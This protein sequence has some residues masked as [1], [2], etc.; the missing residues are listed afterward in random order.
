MGA[1]RNLNNWLKFYRN[2]HNLFQVEFFW[3]YQG[4]F[5]SPLDWQCRLIIVSNIVLIEI[6]IN[7][8]TKKERPFKSLSIWILVPPSAL[9]SELASTFQTFCFCLKSVSFFEKVEGICSSL[10]LIMRYHLYFVAYT[11]YS[12]ISETSIQSLPLVF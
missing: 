9:T 7:R 6:T 4:Q 2:G 3:E 10:F 8:N 11:Y 12:T 5:S 1:G